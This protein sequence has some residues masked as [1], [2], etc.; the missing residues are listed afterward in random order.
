MDFNPDIFKAYDIRGIYG[1]DFNDNFAFQLGVAFVHYLNRGKFLVASDERNFSKALIDSLMRGIVSAGGDAECL[2]C[3]T[4]PLFYFAFE[5]LGVNGGIMVA[6]SHNAPEYGGFK[7]F[8]ESCEPIDS[9]SGL[10]TIRSF[11]TSAPCAAST[12]HEAGAH[13]EPSR[14]RS[15]SKY[16]GQIKRPEMGKILREYIEFII[17]ES[18]VKQGETG[19][20]KIDVRGN[21]SALEEI[22]LLFDRLD[23]QKHGANFD[24]A[25]S[26]DGDADRLAVFDAK[27]NRIG[28]DFVLGLL[29]RERIGFLSKPKVVHDLRFS[30]GVLEKFEEWGIRSFRSRVGRTFIREEMVRRGAN[31]GGELSGHILFRENNYFELPLMAMLKIL[32]IINKAGKDIGELVEPFKTWENSGEINIATSHWPLATSELFGKLKEKYKDGKID[33]LDGI[34]VEYSDSADGGASW[35]FNLRPSNTEPVLRLVVEARDEELLSRKAEELT[36]IIKAARQAA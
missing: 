17:N 25:F 34:T 36:G 21:S 30:R 28:S 35:W 5:K 7:I 20:L 22:N 24:V 13:C 12:P 18:G 16:G 3:S 10:E 32:E 33:E 31:I 27:N 19:G 6:A 2:G 23:I 14:L 29:T 4:M 8:G 1:E 11:V 15:G 9:G 26:F